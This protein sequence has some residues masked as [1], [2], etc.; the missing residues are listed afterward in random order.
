MV[1]KAKR[2]IEMV[3]AVSEALK[4]RKANPSADEE[5]IMRHVMSFLSEVR[6]REAKV[7]SIA[8][9]NYALKILRQNPKQID[10]AIIEEIVTNIDSI[11]VE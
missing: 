1:D 10:R 11:K 7:E 9:V 4:Y 6:N 3:A 8:A 5:K 2:G